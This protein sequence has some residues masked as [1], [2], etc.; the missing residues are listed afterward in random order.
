MKKYICAFIGWL[1]GAPLILL[2]VILL[3]IDQITGQNTNI[4]LFAGLTC[5]VAG[6]TGY[7]WRMKRNGRY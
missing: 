3:A 7:V 1:L 2:G 6:I 5:V 4:L